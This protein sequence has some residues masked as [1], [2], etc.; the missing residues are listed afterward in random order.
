MSE[1]ATDK[2]E[3]DAHTHASDAPRTASWAALAWGGVLL[4]FCGAVVLWFG[5]RWYQD[6]F[7]GVPSGSVAVPDPDWRPPGIDEKWLSQYTLTDQTGK[8]YGTDDLKG[9][10]AVV[11]FFYTS[12]PTACPRQNAKIKALTQEFDGR[13]VQF[14]SITCEP[15]RDTVKKL[16]IYANEF[17]ADP[18]RWH[19]LTGDEKYIRRIAGEIYFVPVLTSEDTRE[20]SHSERLITIDRWGNIR[21]FY[22]WN[23][24]QKLDEMRDM[25][26]KLLAETEPPPPSESLTP[27]TPPTVDEDSGLLVPAADPARKAPPQQPQA[28]QGQDSTTPVPAASAAEDAQ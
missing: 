6:K 26:R 3:F 18:E 28:D 15:M 14:V 8:H 1:H 23:D 19:F 13:E 20:I 25:L 24:P 7:G 10:V 5:W 22:S 17:G 21:G 4:V 27:T 9:K 2:P 12:C 11:S 16:A